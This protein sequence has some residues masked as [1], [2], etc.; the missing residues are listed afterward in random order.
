MTANAPYSP[1][2]SFS[3]AAS[4]EE[5]NEEWKPSEPKA[6]ACKA[7]RDPAS[8]KLKAPLKRTAKSTQPQE[9]AQ[10]Q[11]PEDAAHP[12]P[13]VLSN[14]TAEKRT[15]AANVLE[16]TGES[17]LPASKKKQRN[18]GQK[19]SS[20]GGRIKKQRSNGPEEETANKSGPSNR[21]KEEV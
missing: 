18:E 12:K 17:A 13:E 3:Q 19:K 10:P 8:K 21:M 7:K 9:S 11:A 2:R 15:K 16:N 4:S 5:D 1:I 20:A 14:P 6:K